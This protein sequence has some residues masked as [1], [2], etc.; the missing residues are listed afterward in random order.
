[1]FVCIHVFVYACKHVCVCVCVCFVRACR[2]VGF[3]F[4][5]LTT[6]HQIASADG[7][8]HPGQCKVRVCGWGVKRIKIGQLNILILFT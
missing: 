3:K 8:N 2:L 4:S 5:S 7:L 1:M 6:F